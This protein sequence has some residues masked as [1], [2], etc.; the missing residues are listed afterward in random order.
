MTIQA[1]QP[2]YLPQRLRRSPNTLPERPELPG[3]GQP[4]L[5]QS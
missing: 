4:E 5:G 2:A 1:G 3:R